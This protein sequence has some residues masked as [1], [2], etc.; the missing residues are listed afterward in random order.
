MIP[1]MVSTLGVNTP[2]KVPN[3]A[4]SSSISR[5]HSYRSLA[6]CPGL[7]MSYAR[8]AGLARLQQLARYF[9]GSTRIDGDVTNKGSSLY[10]FRKWNPVSLCRRGDH[11]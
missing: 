8:L 4:R 3:R 1:N 5:T 11:V 6:R 7:M 2:A 9:A 10:N